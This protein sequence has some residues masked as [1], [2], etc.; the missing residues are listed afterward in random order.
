MELPT[1]TQRKT[2]KKALYLMHSSFFLVRRVAGLRYVQRLPLYLDHTS[3]FKSC[4]D[5]PTS[6]EVLLV[7]LL[8]IFI[9][10]VTGHDNW[11]RFAFWNALLNNLSFLPIYICLL[12]TRS[13]LI[14]SLVLLSSRRQFRLSART[15]AVFLMPNRCCPSGNYCFVWQLASQANLRGLL[16]TSCY[17]IWPLVTIFVC[18]AAKKAAPLISP[19]IFICLAV[20][21][22]SLVDAFG[23]LRHLAETFLDDH[24]DAKCGPN[25]RNPIETFVTSNLPL[26]ITDHCP[27]VRFFDLL[28]RISL[29]L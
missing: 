15:H 7:G 5:H 20:C 8:Q 17:A 6:E 25:G 18:L 23:Q 19:S 12:Q 16:K 3:F 4:F 28:S 14:T 1:N 11:S 21:W 24:R 9:T 26:D 2:H 10:L 13:G 29:C 27:C 22:Y